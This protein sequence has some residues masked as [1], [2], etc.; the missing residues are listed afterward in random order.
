MMEINKE[1][2]IDV[3]KQCYD[4]EIPVDLWNL[5]LIYD[6]KINKP[7]VD[8]TMSLTTPGCGMAQLM[9]EDIKTKVT[10]LEGV[11]EATVEITFDPP[12]KPEMMSDEAKEKLGFSPSK[13][14]TE[15]SS[16]E[17]E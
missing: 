10:G 11:D 15:Q 2:V 4:P 7:N 8:I 6:I 3:L 16:T 14:Q 1:Q 12:W 5:G 13:S 17:W 9:A